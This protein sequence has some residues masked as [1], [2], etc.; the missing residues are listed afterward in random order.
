MLLSRFKIPRTLIGREAQLKE[1]SGDRSR[2]VVADYHPLWRQ[3]LSGLLREQLGL[4]VVAEA[5]DGREAVDCCRHLGPDAVIMDVGWLDAVR[6]M[7]GGASVG[8][9]WQRVAYRLSSQFKYT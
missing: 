6:S 2:V 3:A 7:E 9:P 8:L 4:E 5:A 1:A